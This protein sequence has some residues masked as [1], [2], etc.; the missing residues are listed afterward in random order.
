MKERQVTQVKLAAEFRVSQAAVSKWLKGTVPSGETLV[1]LARFF[2]VPPGEM[3]GLESPRHPAAKS[4]SGPL[5][6]QGVAG[7]SKTDS[8]ARVDAELDAILGQLKSRVKAGLLGRP[9]EEVDCRLRTLRDL[10]GADKASSA[11][12]KK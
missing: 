10:F 1:R 3:V 11:K 2:G 7:R 6:T 9:A 8:L 4:Q 5:P 12:R